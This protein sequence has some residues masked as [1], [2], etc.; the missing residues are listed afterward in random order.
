MQHAVSASVHFCL[1][2]IKNSLDSWK[3][4]ELDN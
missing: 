4:W 1:Y 3:A 2:Y